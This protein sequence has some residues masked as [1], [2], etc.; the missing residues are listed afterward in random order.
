MYL[1]NNASF[2]EIPVGLDAVWDLKI[3]GVTA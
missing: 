1:V 2:V 3:A